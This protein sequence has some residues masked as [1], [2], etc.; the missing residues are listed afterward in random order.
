MKKSLSLLAMYNSLG[1]TPSIGEWVTPS[2]TLNSP[3]LPTSLDDLAGTDAKKPGAHFKGF[4]WN[5]E[6][7]PPDWVAE[8][9][10]IPGWLSED[11]RNGWFTSFGFLD[12]DE[13]DQ[14]IL[15]K[16]TRFMKNAFRTH[17]RNRKWSTPDYGDRDP[18]GEWVSGIVEKFRFNPSYKILPSFQKKQARGNV[19]DANGNE[20]KK[21]G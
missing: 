18:V 2:G 21:K 14:E 4:R 16:T 19:F 1:L 11:D 9:T 20:C 10:N 17:Y 12:Y 8:I 6:I 13:W 5:D 15:R 3:K 7:D